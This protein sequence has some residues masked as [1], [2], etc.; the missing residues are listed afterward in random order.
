MSYPADQIAVLKSYC[1]T[2]SLLTEGG[3]NYLL[4]EGLQLPKGCEPSICD[5]LF[6]PWHGA[7]NYPSQLFFSVQLKSSYPRN[8][9]VF[10]VRLCE[11]NWFAFSW[12]VTPASRALG[13]ILLGHLTGFTKEG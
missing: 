4:L 7:D 3:Q 2:V 6:R 1:A 9:N 13:D 5:A 11:R 12:R 10:N 8:W